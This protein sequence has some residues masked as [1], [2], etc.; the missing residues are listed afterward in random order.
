MSLI[1][2][3]PRSATVRAVAPTLMLRMSSE[4]VEELL[5]RR[6]PKAYSLFIMNIARELSRR[7]RV[8]DGILAQFVNTVSE[9]HQLHD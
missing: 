8:A 6:D 5:Y 7:L 2:V 1:D 4:D 9:T 3:Q